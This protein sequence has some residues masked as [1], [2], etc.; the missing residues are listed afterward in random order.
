MT[1][2]SYRKA[3]LTDAPALS[4]LHG[5][6]ELCGAD[7]Y[8]MSRYIAGQ[9]HPEMALRLRTVLV[10]TVNDAPIAYIAGHLTL[11]FGCH[12]EIQWIYVARE[13]RRSHVANQ[14]L[15]LQSRWFVQ[16]RAFRI[17]ADVS[18]ERVRQLYRRHGAD[19]H[20]AHW[21]I[22]DNIG[23]SFG[24]DSGLSRAVTRCPSSS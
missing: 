24:H 10:A 21:V 20:I 12:G 14:L 22:W 6:D 4:R 18:D 9:H 15:R 1:T 19:D 2:V 17:C 11:R 5:E 13:H 3:L 7:E 23:V 8:R 16:H